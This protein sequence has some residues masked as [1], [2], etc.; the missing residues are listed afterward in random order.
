[1]KAKGYTVDARVLSMWRREVTILNSFLFSCTIYTG[2]KGGVCENVLVYSI[3]KHKVCNS[4]TTGQD[5][6]TAVKMCYV[7]VTSSQDAVSQ[8]DI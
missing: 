8:L 1:M 6:M 7:R 4:V 5:Q 2:E 3:S